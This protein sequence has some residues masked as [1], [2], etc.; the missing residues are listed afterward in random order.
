M[1]YIL[2]GVWGRKTRVIDY[3]FNIWEPL[4]SGDQ[5]LELF[6]SLNAI[7]I[8]FLIYLFLLTF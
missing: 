1:S 5:T 3:L 6:I 2:V 4:R 7:L 8:L